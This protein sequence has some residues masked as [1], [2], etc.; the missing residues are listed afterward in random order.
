MI[1]RTTL[2]WVLA[3]ASVVLAVGLAIALVSGCASEPSAPAGSGG[4]RVVLATEGAAGTFVSS[5]Q[6]VGEGEEIPIRSLLL[7]FDAIRVFPV[8]EKDGGCGGVGDSGECPFHEALERPVTVDAIALGD[9]LQA[10]L[11]DLDLPAG[12]YSHLVLR[13]T[14]ATATREDGNQVAVELPGRTDLKVLV[15][16]RVEEGWV[17][18]LALVLD[19][20]KSVYQSR[21]GGV[22]SLH[23]VI[24]GSVAAKRAR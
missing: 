20:G 9:S 1:R 10:R 6:A 18:E 23:P 22:Y 19:L 16:F 14:E 15:P 2:S 4:A 12:G 3:M 11:A 13:I 21:P 24:G 7:T 17:T 5:P 8:S